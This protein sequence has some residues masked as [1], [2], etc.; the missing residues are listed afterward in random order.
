MW[1]F[2]SLRWNLHISKPT[3]QA[4]SQEGK[5]SGGKIHIDIS[6]FSWVAAF[7]YPDVFN[8][9]LFPPPQGNKAF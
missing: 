8:N 5:Q 1:R 6:E 9:G 4:V 7:R 2:K 3:K